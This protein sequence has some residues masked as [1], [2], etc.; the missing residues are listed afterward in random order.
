MFSDVSNVRDRRVPKY[1][2]C[3]NARYSDDVSVRMMTLFLKPHESENTEVH[4]SL[5]SFNDRQLARTT[6]P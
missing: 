2:T 3:D 4:F 5:L 6:L 1:G